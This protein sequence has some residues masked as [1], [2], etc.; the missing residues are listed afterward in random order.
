MFVEDV[1]S[2]RNKST[3]TPVWTPRRRIADVFAST[4][5]MPADYPGYGANLIG[6]GEL[7]EDPLRGHAG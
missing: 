4:A 7:Q 5:K 2:Q 6:F 1:R 3:R